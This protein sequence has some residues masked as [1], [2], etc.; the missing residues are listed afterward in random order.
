MGLS[1]TSINV[2]HKVKKLL[3]QFAASR[4]KKMS[5]T[6]LFNILQD[7]SESLKYYPSR[8]N[9]ATIRVIPHKQEIF[10]ETFQN[11]INA[12]PFNEPLAQKSSLSLAKVVTRTECYVKGKKRNTEKKVS[13]ANER[14]H[15]FERSRHSRKS[16]YISYIKDKIVFKRAVKATKNFT[17]LNIRREHILSKVLHLNKI[18]TLTIP[19]A[20][21]MGPEPRRCASSTESRDTTLKIDFI[22]KK[23]SKG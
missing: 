19:K 3:H 5:T 2:Y 17:P 4:H 23:I 22:P 15:N 7:P 6:S 1:R 13:D 10:V 21:V 12:C 18:P 16:N 8:F 14:I 11:G 9:E 20:Y